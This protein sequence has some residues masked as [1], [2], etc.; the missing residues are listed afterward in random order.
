MHWLEISWLTEFLEQNRALVWWLGSLSL[1]MFLASLL[2]TPWLIARLPADY[3]TTTGREHT[4]FQHHPGLRLPMRILRNVFGYAV[5]LAGLAMLIFPGQGVLTVV[6]GLLLIDFPGKHRLVLNLVQRP[7]VHRGLNWIRR[8]MHASEL[9]ME[10][11]DG[12]APSSGVSCAPSASDP[13]SD[14]S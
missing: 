9:E 5:L 10:G 6:V 4:I 7:S 12:Q 2:L 13:P 11:I 1:A 8:R 14:A 3:F